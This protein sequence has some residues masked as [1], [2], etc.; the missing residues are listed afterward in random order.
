MSGALIVEGMLDPFPQLQ[1]ITE[2]IMLLKDFQNIDGQI[3]GGGGLV[4]QID[5]DA[6]T[7]RTLNGLVN[8]TIKI[9]P[10]ETQFWRIGHVSAD[11]S[12][13]LKLDCHTFNE[14]ARD[15]DRHTRV[16]PFDEIVL[17]PGSRTEVLVYGGAQGLYQL[18]TLYYNQ[19]ADGDQYPEVTLAT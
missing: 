16:V 1:G 6:G 13:R 2:R 14:I 12:Y 5:S 17:P 19:G 9:R 4:G 3:P 7:T 15:G 10:G 18:R 11:I 8:P